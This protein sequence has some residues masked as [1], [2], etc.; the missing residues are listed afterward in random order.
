VT[1]WVYRCEKTLADCFN[2]RSIVGLGAC[3]RGAQ[4]I[5]PDAGDRC[6]CVASFRGNLP[7]ETGFVSVLCG[8]FRTPRESR[9]VFL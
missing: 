1:L 7:R 4:A 3:V 8:E 9:P 2:F 6:R 5:S